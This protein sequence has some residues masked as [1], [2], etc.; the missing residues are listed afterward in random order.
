M[1]RGFFA[2]PKRGIFPAQ[3]LLQFARSVGAQA[4]YTYQRHTQFIVVPYQD[5]YLL[6]PEAKNVKRLDLPSLE[7]PQTM[8]EWQEVSTILSQEYRII[9]STSA[10]KFMDFFGA[11][12]IYNKLTFSPSFW[13]V[14]SSF[15]ATYGRNK[16]VHVLA[17]EENSKAHFLLIQFAMAQRGYSKAKTVYITVKPLST[18][19]LEFVGKDSAV[20]SAY[21]FENLAQQKDRL[22]APRASRKANS[23]KQK[24][25]SFVLSHY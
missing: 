16:A 25:H 17:T 15:V 10:D 21:A 20:P 19:A 1:T 4:Y 8:R 14:V 22:R 2:D 12:P 3:E 18:F 24:L 13:P 11:C 23:L 6:R 5:M 7:L 9:G